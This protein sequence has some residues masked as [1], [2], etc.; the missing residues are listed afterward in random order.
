MA[1]I[2]HS[3]ITMRYNRGFT[4]DSKPRASLSH[5][6]SRGTLL[7]VAAFESQIS[8]V[9]LNLRTAGLRALP[10]SA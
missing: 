4:R 6:L 7:C 10:L 5:L 3:R 1:V 2:L 9:L 8:K